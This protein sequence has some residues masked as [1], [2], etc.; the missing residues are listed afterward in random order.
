VN[1]LVVIAKEPLPGQ[2]KTRLTSEFSPAE[3]A[4][5]AAAALRDT[6]AVVSAAPARRRVLLFQGDAA[7]WAPPDWTVL[8]QCAGTLDVRL[9]HG[10]AAVGALGGGPALLVGMDTPQ[11]RVERLAFDAERYDSCLGLATDGGFWA[12]GFR[13]PLLAPTAMLGVPMSVAETG[14]AQHDRLRA[15]GLS[16]QELAPLPDFDTPSDA[17]ELA[18]AAPGTQFAQA[19][20]AITG[21][22]VGSRP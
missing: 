3:A 1:T 19:W 15:A 8:P 4:F 9:G 16:V 10:L 7:G 6:I 17:R 21:A 12:I 18:L 5:L 13:D 22:R 2:V 20:Q 11:L 14:L